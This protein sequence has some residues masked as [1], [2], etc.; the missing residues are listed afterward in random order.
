MVHLAQYQPAF[1]ALI[2]LNAARSDPAIL[3]NLGVV[4]LR[5]TGPDAASA[6]SYFRSATQADNTDS[7]LFFNLGYA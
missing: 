1:T 6:V 4:Q 5:R 7:D 2:E 3:S